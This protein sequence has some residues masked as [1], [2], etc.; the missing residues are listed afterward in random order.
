MAARTVPSLPS[1]LIVVMYLIY[2]NLTP[3]QQ[4]VPTT[5]KIPIPSSSNNIRIANSLKTNYNNN[6]MRERALTMSIQGPKINPI[7]NIR[8]GSVGSEQVIGN[9]IPIEKNL[10]FFK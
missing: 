7:A 8:S 10:E 1:E 5:N 9:N 6:Q 2:T 4:N 3:R